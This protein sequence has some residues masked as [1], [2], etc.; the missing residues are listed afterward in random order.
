MTMYE[1]DITRF[2][3]ELMDNNP[4]LKELQKANRATWWDRKLDQH[5]LKRLQESEAPQA[6]LRVFSAAQVSGAISA[7]R[8][9]ISSS[10]PRNSAITGSDQALRS[11]SVRCKYTVKISLGGVT[12]ACAS[13][14]PTA[15]RW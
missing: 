9:L 2:I 10:R 4:Q 1:S 5:E 3:R 11:G 12:D 8:Q 14:R 6:T 7:R 15:P 13:M